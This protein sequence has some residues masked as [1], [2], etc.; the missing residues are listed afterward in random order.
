LRVLLLSVALLRAPRPVF[1]VRHPYPTPGPERPE[2]AECAP[3]IA[4]RARR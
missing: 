1:A 3:R 2:G 4:G